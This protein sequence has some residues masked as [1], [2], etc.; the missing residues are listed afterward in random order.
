VRRHH[1]QRHVP[2]L[3]ALA[4]AAEEI[5]IRAVLSNDVADAEHDLDTLRTKQGA[6]EASTARATAGR[7]LHRHRVA[8]A[9]VRGLLQDAGLLADELGPASTST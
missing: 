2:K 4:D 1:G 6:F 7:G 9:G 3:D 8:A 5:G